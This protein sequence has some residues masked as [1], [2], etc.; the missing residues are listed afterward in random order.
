MA[1][2]HKDHAA[3]DHTHG[4]MDIRAHERTFDGF[5]HMCMWVAIISFV[6]LIFLALVNS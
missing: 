2:H 3:T 5:V 1:T 4:E 6:I